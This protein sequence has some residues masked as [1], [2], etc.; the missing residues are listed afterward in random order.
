[1]TFRDTPSIR[2]TTDTG[3]RA[4]RRVTQAPQFSEFCR[5]CE[6][7]SA[8]AAL[9]A[10]SGLNLPT[11]RNV[12][13][14]FC[15]TEQ[16]VYE[17]SFFPLPSVWTVADQLHYHPPVRR[18]QLAGTTA[19]GSCLVDRPRTHMARQRCLLQLRC[20]LGKHRPAISAVRRFRFSR[21]RNVIVG[22]SNAN[23]C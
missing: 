22:E 5:K 23:N 6:S 10:T 19:S 13:G 12:S 2:S 3:V 4:R 21:R 17:S 7:Q 8:S 16:I 18:L 20:R 15:R 11:M 14:C 9:P 1:M